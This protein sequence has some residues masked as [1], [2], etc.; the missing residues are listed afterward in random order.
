MQYQKSIAHL[1]QEQSHSFG[2]HQNCLAACNLPRW[3]LASSALWMAPFATWLHFSVSNAS[4]LISWKTELLAALHVLGGSIHLSLIYWSWPFTI[5]AVL[6][7]TPLPR[8]SLDSLSTDVDR[9]RLLSMKWR[10][11]A[12]AWLRFWVASRS[13]WFCASSC[14]ICWVAAAC[15][16]CA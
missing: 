2:K 1:I 3:L 6:D 16:A 5:W 14:W 10:A 13:C 8:P 9:C 12:R 15:R 4:A 11:C 7:T